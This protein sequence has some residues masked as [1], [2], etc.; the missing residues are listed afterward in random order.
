MLFCFV[1]I[2]GVS[3]NLNGQ[4]SIGKESAIGHLKGYTL[5][6]T[7]CN[8]YS[9]VVA[10]RNYIQNQGGSVAIIGTKNVMLG[11]IDSSLASRLVGNCG[12]TAIYYKPIDIHILTTTDRQTLQT[13]TFFNSA[14]SGDLEKQLLHEK[15][16]SVK[17]PDF[18]DG[19]PHPAISYDDYLKNIERK[20]L[21]I[22]DLK[23]KNQLLQLKADGSLLT[24]NSDVMVGT[25]TVAVFFVQSNGMIDPNLYAWSTAD[26]DSIYQRT[27]SDLSWWSSIAPKYGKAV[28]FNVIPHYHT[29]TVCQQPYEPILH[30][31]I[32][33]GLWIGSIMSK[34]GFQTGGYFSEVEAYNTWLRSTYSTD[35]AYSIFFAYNPLPAPNAFT[36]GYG[37]YAYLGGPYTQILF[38]WF[39]GRPT[40]AH[41]SGHIFWAVDEYYEAGYGG[42]GD[43]ATDTKS[44]F[45]NG[46]CEIANVNSVECMM[47]YNTYNLCA[48]TPAHIGWLTDVPQYT[49]T[50]SPPGLLISVD[51]EQRVSPQ[52]F[53]WGL[54]S[55][56][57]ISVVTPQTLNGKK[58]NFLSWSDGEAQS[59]PITIPNISMSYIANFSLAGDAPQ[60][61]Q[62]Y[63]KTNALPS[64]GV[65]VVMSDGQGNMWVGTDGGLSKFDGNNWI[66]YNASN[67][68]IPNDNI[69]T[70]VAADMQGNKWIGMLPHWNGSAFVGGGFAK[71]DGTIWTVYNTSNS[72][73]PDNNVTSIA[74]DDSG[75]KWIATEGGLAKFDG[76]NWTVYTTSNSGLPS[77]YLTSIL[78][79]G[80]GNK[81]IGTSSGLA[82][83]DG[84]NWTTYTTSNSGLPGNYLTS[85]F[86]D[87]SG[88]KWIGTSSGLAKFDG[89]NW[90]T[91]TTS[92]SG[93]P[94]NYTSSIAIDS[95]GNKWIGTSS[96]LAKF[97]GTSWSVYTT[98]NLGL[99]NNYVSSISIDGSGNKWIGTSSGLAKFDGTSWSVYTTSNLGLP[100]NYVSS[101]S[102]DGSGNKWIGTSSGLA[103]FDGTNWTTYTISNSGLPSN[104]LTSIFIDGS[105]NKWIGTS[106]G[107]AKFDGTNWTVYNSSNSGLPDNYVISIAIDSSGKK[108]I[109]TYAG[110]AKFDG[111]N[112]TT[113]TT[114][115]SGLPGNYI[116]S[117]ATDNSNNKWI[118][119]DGGLGKFNGTTWTVY[120]SSNS[121]LPYNYVTSITIDS[122][123][124]KWIG[125][126]AGLTKFDG[127][128]WTVYNSSNSG[129]PDNYIQPIAIDGSGNK[130]IGTYAG[131]TKFDGT[132]WTTYTTS[133]SG[134][135]SNYVISIATDS[136][137]KKWIGTDGGGLAVYKEGGVTS[138]KEITNKNTP[139]TFALF[140]NYPN[141]FNPS[142]NISFNLPAK[143]FVSLKVYDLLGREVAALAAQTMSAGTHA[144]QWNAGKMPSGVYFYRLKA[145]TFTQTK[146][147][148]LLK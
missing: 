141:P 56:M 53:P 24:G 23:N 49:V 79:D 73:L 74:I 131:L 19:F 8:D 148:V 145:G 44:G 144:L 110:L 34:L 65:H 113:Y 91:Y 50:T 125:T 47:H 77:N 98:S 101:I 71:F 37:G 146:K 127:T 62:L 80:S 128:N 25:V 20:K 16:T 31:S 89:T 93:L 51:G 68:G 120:N 28:S 17:K 130:W 13:L 78:I 64:P 38:T 140:Q 102:I 139:E 124:N 103:K 21:S 3:A 5:I 81:W 94:S 58:Y 138:V 123:N 54:G 95:S 109:G 126:Y 7:S 117:I 96:G 82:K 66:T 6:L 75:N 107:L 2:F 100:N 26:E 11:W 133:N 4:V 121:G 114:S 85:I 46:N 147:L 55:Q 116:F 39:N 33:D 35:W 92:N 118:G 57:E 142:T 136:S 32:E 30:S 10:A 40:V 111:T 108:W 105:G 115:N 67:S 69:V 83:F 72:G 129:L 106:S 14:V 41:E 36:N 60:T 18:Y 134:L 15:G 45:P 132:N 52:I 12:I 61:W 104:D 27:L 112:W 43:G 99:P 70:V 87:G 119:T 90:T 86:I 42:C 76:T 97:D 135:P 122:S 1:I 143:S 88:N 84:T 59:H 9:E 22:Q 29:D 48:F 63:Q 137:G